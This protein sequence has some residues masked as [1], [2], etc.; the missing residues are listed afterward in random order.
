MS[1]NVISGIKANAWI[2]NVFIKYTTLQTNIYYKLC[3]EL[4]NTRTLYLKHSG[5]GTYHYYDVKD[6]EQFIVE[7]LEKMIEDAPDL[8]QHKFYYTTNPK[9]SGFT[10]NV[11]LNVQIQKYNWENR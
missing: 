8:F 4:R 5:K 10:V 6:V 2:W 9:G 7:K 11:P 1:N 3:K